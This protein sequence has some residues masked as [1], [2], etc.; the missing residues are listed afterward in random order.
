[1]K[2]LLL[3]A[4]CALLTV[5]GASAQ[6]REIYTSPKFGALAKGHKSLAVLPFAVTLQLRPN[7][8]TKNG[9]PEGVAKLEQ[10]EG[11]DVQNALHSYFLK[12]KAE[13]DITVD[14][15]DPARTNALL[16]QNGVTAANFATFTPEQLAKFLGVDGIISGTFNSTQPMS[17]GAAVAMSMLVGVSGPTNTGK[18]M[19]NINDGATGEL[20]W[21]YDK[22]LSRGFGSDTN[23]IVT[24]I[25]RKASRQFPYS[26]E[27]KG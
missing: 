9:G 16:V 20:L 18:L 1:M 24:T 4:L 13:N 27:F 10:R 6:T 14:V 7:E 15:Q 5:M 12:R 25:M 11:L 23:T 22:S 19:I 8:V 26:K 21:K 17:A 2:S 3:A